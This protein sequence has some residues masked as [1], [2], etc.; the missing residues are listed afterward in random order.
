MKILVPIDKGK[1]LN[2]PDG[3][4][5]VGPELV[6]PRDIKLK[7]KCFK[8]GAEF[9]VKEPSLG[10]IMTM[11]CPKCHARGDFL[12]VPNMVYRVTGILKDGRI[13]RAGDKKP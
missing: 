3:T 5:K 6:I 1:P 7:F 2:I 12:D 8:C 13:I 4:Y 9:E 11:E 10:E